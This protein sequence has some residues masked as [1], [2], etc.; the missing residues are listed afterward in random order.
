MTATLEILGQRC[1]LG[2]LLGA[3]GMGRV[4]AVQHPTR[5]RLA[6]KLL[7]EAL[8]D[9]PVMIGRLREEARA[10]R[11]VV[12]RN[13]VRILDGGEATDGSPFVVMEH[14]RG[15]SLGAL[16]NREGPLGLARIRAIASQLLDGLAAL[17][18][19]G[20]VHGDMKSDNV[21]VDTTAAGDH[22][23]IIDLGLVRPSE[24][25]TAQLPPRVVSGTPQYMAPEQIRGE[26]LTPATDLYAVG[27]ILYEMLTGTTP[28]DGGPTATVFA[29]HL[30]DD[31]VPPSLRSS[32]REIPVAL[33]DVIRRA[34]EKDPADR[35]PD[36]SALAAA[37]ERAL[38]AG[39]AECVVPSRV[40]T[41]STSAPTREWVRPHASP[42]PRR[43]LA[44]AAAPQDSARVKCRRDE[45]LEAIAT[46]DP[47]AIA[48]ASLSLVQALVVDHRLTEAAC[49]LEDAAS[50]LSS[51][52]DAPESLWRVLLTLAAIYDGLGDR[53]RARRTA[54]DAGEAAARA[55]SP[56][57]RA[58]ANALLRRF[59]AAVMSRCA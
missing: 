7:N 4:Y 40:A 33:D 10:A 14:V 31:V 17:H 34:L 5:A 45:L 44:G 51:E 21:L 26:P 15:I 36:A 13:L 23:T 19:A 1:V 50:L 24:T 54:L 6:V 37:V 3:G 35:Y 58:R 39:Y 38:P 8:A 30:A 55:S 2:D 18:R 20:L 53:V 59:D 28:F 42:P 16:V 41:D 47:D 32:D 49:E 57:G 27:V 52:H 9:D 11:G 56:T 12:H 48:V 29:R 22:V 46:C 25:S 43:H